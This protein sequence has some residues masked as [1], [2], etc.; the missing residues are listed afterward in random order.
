MKLRLLSVL[1]LAGCV[2][3][4][5]KPET[6][7]WTQTYGHNF[8][9]TQKGNGF[10]FDFPKTDGV[11]YITKPSNPLK[12]G[13][14]ITVTYSMSGSGFATVQK[15]TGKPCWRVMFTKVLDPYAT[16]PGRYWSTDYVALTTTKT[17]TFS[18]K[19]DPA[20]WTD[21]YG[22]KGSEH[23]DEFKTAL[24]GGHIGLTFGGTTGGYGH[25]VTGNGTFTL[26]S[27]EVK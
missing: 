2:S 23:L 3:V 26:T 8:T 6:N 17:K 10:T 14:T 25:G 15:N 18:V 22:A 27:M 11:H 13:Q 4:T 9:L 5:P 12:I 19:I 16:N 7:G 24:T 1:I 21:V 20:L